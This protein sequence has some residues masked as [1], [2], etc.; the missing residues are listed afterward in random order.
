MD[1]LLLSKEMF[2]ADAANKAVHGARE[3]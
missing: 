1:P 3:S 2:I